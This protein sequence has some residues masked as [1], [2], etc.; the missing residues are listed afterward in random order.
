MISEWPFLMPQV[1]AHGTTGPTAEKNM[2]S[3][4]YVSI[5]KTVIFIS[6]KRIEIKV[7]LLRRPIFLNVK[8][9]E[10]F[11]LAFRVCAGDHVDVLRRHRSFLKP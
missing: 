1:Q 10:R 8:F 11:L 3:L 9:G 6:Y 7:F 2:F 4:F 5:K